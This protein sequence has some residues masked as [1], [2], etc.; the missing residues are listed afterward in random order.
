M[1]LFSIVI[2]CFNEGTRLTRVLS[3]IT[4]QAGND[5]EIILVNDGS[6]DNTAEVAETWRQQFPYIQCIA[7][8]NQ[9]PASA[10]N[11]G[12]RYAQGQ[13]ILLLDA[14][15]ELTFDSLSVWRNAIAAHNNSSVIISQ[16]YTLQSNQTRKLSAAPKISLHCADNFKAFLRKKLTIAHGAILLK[17]N[18]FDTLSYP[19]ELIGREDTVFFGQVLARYTCTTLTKPTVIIHRRQD[20]LRHHTDNLSFAAADLLFNAE[21][22]PAN[23]MAFE[24]NYRASLALSNFRLLFNQKNYAQ[25]RRWYYH[26]LQL[27]P[28]K[29]FAWS[30]FKKYIRSL[31]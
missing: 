27:A 31:I 4:Q 9:G 28:H 24:K 14:D 19:A 16:H 3:S 8:S 21:I 23:C 22:L 26:A 25:A 12:I 6:T 11:H 10:R 1:V 15:D 2:P 29:L 18:I 13:Y 17:R 7:Q 5:Y 30:Y 20:S